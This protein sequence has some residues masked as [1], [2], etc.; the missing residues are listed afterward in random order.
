[1]GELGDERRAMRTVIY[2]F[3]GSGNSLVVARD[4]A[5]A[6]GGEAASIAAWMERVPNGPL[7]PAAE[8]VGL[9]FP[10]YYANMGGSG[11]PAIVERFVARL[12]GLA[13]RYV[14]AVCAHG[15]GPEATVG[16]LARMVT[17]RGGTLAAG[18]VVQLGRP[19]PTAAKLRHMLTRAPLRTNPAETELRR[20]LWA[21]WQ[22]RLPGM[23]SCIAARA[24]A[25]L[26]TTGASLRAVRDA[27]MALQRRMA[28]ARFRQLA[29]SRT[30][31]L[32]ELIPRS[33]AAFAVSARCNGC[34]T[35]ARVCPVGNIALV[36]GR[37]VWQHR[38]ETCCACY[39]WCPQEAIGGAAV[40]FEKRY[41]PPAVRLADVLV[42]V[43]EARDG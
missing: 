9:A 23:A 21:A 8:A 41:H 32:A 5:A 22:A 1:M 7:V 19:Y 27:F 12:D 33:D 30:G 28:L 42:H 39:Q 29:G 35:C 3:T 25:P 31:A 36:A 18:W 26:E 16:N 15:G 10:V 38:C 14:F 43:A 2:Y 4:L 6:T 13:G 34:G 17:A 40:E 20:P 11:V 37:P 24:D